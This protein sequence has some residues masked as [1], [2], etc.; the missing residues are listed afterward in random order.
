[1]IYTH[2]IRQIFRDVGFFPKFMYSNYELRPIQ[3]SHMK[4]TTWPYFIQVH[5]STTRNIKRPFQNTNYSIWYLWNIKSL[6]H[7]S[8]ILIRKKY[9]WQKGLFMSIQTS[10]TK[11]AT[12][13]TTSSSSTIDFFTEDVFYQAQ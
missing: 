9:S 7:L 2:F 6:K 5:S 10:R 4:H 12:Q 11:R 3:S 1:M 13:A 8:L